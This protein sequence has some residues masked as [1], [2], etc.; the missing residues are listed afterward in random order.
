MWGFHPTS[1]PNSFLRCHDSMIVQDVQVGII[2]FPP[3]SFPMFA[4]IPQQRLGTRQAAEKVGAVQTFFLQLRRLI[5]MFDPKVH[6]SREKNAWHVMKSSYYIVSV[7]GKFCSRC[8]Q[9]CPSWF[10]F[11]HAFT[12]V[13]W[14]LCMI[15]DISRNTHEESWGHLCASRPPALHTAV[16]YIDYIWHDSVSDH[17]SSRMGR[18]KALGST[19]FAGMKPKFS[20]YFDATLW[21]TNI[22]MEN[23]HFL[24]ENPL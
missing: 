14:Q 19:T 12:K 9:L 4:D 15:Y 2:V 22:A 20:D 6:W 1:S 21:W 3:A 13:L 11:P 23:H 18:I 16:T 5:E 24:W 8:S 7:G 17:V 10:V